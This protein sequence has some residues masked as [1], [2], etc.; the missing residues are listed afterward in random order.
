M[1]KKKFVITIF[2]FSMPHWKSEVKSR[3]HFILFRFVVRMVDSTNN[4]KCEICVGCIKQIQFKGRKK[5]WINGEKVV[6]RS[7]SRRLHTLIQFN[8]WTVH[9]H[10]QVYTDY[11][12]VRTSKIFIFVGWIDEANR[13]EKPKYFKLKLNRWDKQCES[14]NVC[15][16]PAPRF[17]WIKFH[18][19]AFSAETFRPIFFCTQKSYLIERVLK[20]CKTFRNWKVFKGVSVGVKNEEWNLII[21]KCI[22]ASRSK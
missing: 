17:I 16:V 14:Y 6:K 19:D 18:F 2:S 11:C 15:H 3:F 5:R 8:R 20:W 13:S 12:L 22:I 4:E 7:E 10:A 21:T 1:Q 9:K